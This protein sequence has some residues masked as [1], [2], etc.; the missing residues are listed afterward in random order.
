MDVPEW[1]LPFCCRLCCEA[2]QVRGLP[3]ESTPLSA[4]DKNIL[5]KQLQGH[6]N[7][8]PMSHRCTGIMTEIIAYTT[9][10]V[11]GD[12]IIISGGSRSHTSS[13]GTTYQVANQPQ[14]YRIIPFRGPDGTLYLDNAGTILVRF[15]H[16][17][18]EVLLDN[19]IGLQ[20]VWQRQW[21]ADKLEAPPMTLQKSWWN[22]AVKP[23]IQAIV[24]RGSGGTENDGSSKSISI[25]DEMMLEMSS[26][27]GTVKQSEKDGSSKSTSIA[28][29]I[30]KLKQHLDDGIL[31]KEEFEAAKAKIIG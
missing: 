23:P 5:T 15:S 2:P 6:W 17:M 11:S 24:D 22:G 12:K 20:L 28:D 1:Q 26:S 14:E 10:V 29:E 7:I 9:V 16:D 18:G 27:N 21:K 4:F 8:K 3:L 19:A 25:K 13:D 30:A 31:T